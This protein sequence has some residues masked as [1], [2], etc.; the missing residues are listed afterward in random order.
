MMTDKNE[1]YDKK[2]SRLIIESEKWKQEK[3]H[4]S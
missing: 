3:V 1:I 4:I 2:F